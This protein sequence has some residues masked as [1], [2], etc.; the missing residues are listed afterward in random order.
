MNRGLKRHFNQPRKRS[1]PGKIRAPGRVR[2]GARGIRDARNAAVCQSQTQKPSVSSMRPSSLRSIESTVF[3]T[4]ER[5]LAGVHQSRTITTTR[6][7]ANEGRLVTLSRGPSR[8]SCEAP[9]DHSR[10]DNRSRRR[11]RFL[12]SQRESDERN[13]SKLALT[14]SGREPRLR[15]REDDWVAKWGIRIA[16]RILL[17]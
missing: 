3:R 12:F 6:A 14:G 2:W 1:N 13:F 7:R 15:A 4:A 9:L 16:S 8:I 5:C 11:C 17:G 10:S